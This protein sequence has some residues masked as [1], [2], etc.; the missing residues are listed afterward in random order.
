MGL[1][2]VVA[3][4]GASVGNLAAQ[5]PDPKVPGATHFTHKD[6]QGYGVDTQDPKKC[7][8]CHSIDAKGT[9]LAPAALGHAPCLT[10][11]C[12]ADT[13]LK[14]SK[15]N[16]ESKD[17]KI[18]AEY[19]KAAGM[20]LGCH[21][22]VPWPW[23]KPTMRVLSGWLNQREHHVEMA[24][25]AKS[26]MDHFA[27]ATTAKKKGGEVVGCRD[28]HAVGAD[29]KL[30]KGA[31]GH[32]QCAQC[33]NAT[34]SIAFTMGECG[35]CHQEGSRTEFLRKVFADRDIKMD[36]KFDVE[37]RPGSDV[38]ACDSGGE[39]AY[40]KKKGK[41][42]CFKHETEGHRTQKGQDVQ[43]KACHF[44]VIDK[45]GWTKGR[46]FNSVADLHVNKI[47]G[48]AFNDTND[49]QHAACSGAK[50]CHKH[51]AQVDINSSGAA[52]T[53]CHAARTKSEPF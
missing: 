51:E 45:N 19:Q 13:F 12:H 5:A 8:A 33:H 52:C 11:G 7:G 41:A 42:P 1:G 44:I 49:M 32:T 31:P 48:N 50:S 27:H 15:K 26:S 9:I 25:S 37:T 35:R 21:E 43:C 30:I 22:Q 17:P 28:C 47:I 2:A 20:C 10:S 36:P 46:T 38:R 39:D 3:I 23:K 18:A 29:F 4:F 6:H 14:V 53:Y 16:S 40:K 24:R 34:D